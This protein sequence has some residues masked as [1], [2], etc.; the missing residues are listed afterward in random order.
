MVPPESHGTLCGLEPIVDRTAP[1]ARTHLSR[2]TVCRTLRNRQSQGNGMSVTPFYLLARSAGYRE[3]ARR[4]RESAN[5]TNLETGPMAELASLLERKA[6]LAE[7]RAW[8]L[9]NGDP[10]LP[11]AE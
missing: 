4:L 11:E 5:G 9:P 10:R 8:S 3:R 6:V 2:G 1:V 7:R